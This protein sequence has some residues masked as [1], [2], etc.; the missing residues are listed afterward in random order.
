MCFSASGVETVAEQCLDVSSAKT[1]VAVAISS[2][3]KQELNSGAAN[4]L[5]KHLC[6]VFVQPSFESICSFK[7]VSAAVDEYFLSP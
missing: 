4:R 2:L 6:L 3:K 7:S 5:K 1:F